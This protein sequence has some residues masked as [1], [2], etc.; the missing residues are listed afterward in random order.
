MI[1]GN[2]TPIWTPRDSVDTA[3]EFGRWADHAERGTAVVE[4][5]RYRRPHLRVTTRSRERRAR[6][7]DAIAVAL[8]MA[9]MAAFGVIVFA[10]SAKADTD[11]RAWAWDNGP[12]V[13]DWLDHNPTPGGLESTARTLFAD[14]MTPEQVGGAVAWSVNDICPR[15]TRLLASYIAYGN[16]VIA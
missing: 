7:M 15:H 12:A 6:F 3:M 14:G 1:P 9:L 10:A 16:A 4:V 2:V 8:L 5:G 11:M 13:C